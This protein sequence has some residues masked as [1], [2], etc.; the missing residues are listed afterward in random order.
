MAISL[1]THQ[2]QLERY[3]FK[4]KPTREDFERMVKNRLAIPAMVTLDKITVLRIYGRRSRLV[5]WASDEGIETNRTAFDQTWANIGLRLVSDTREH[6]LIEVP[7]G[8]VPPLIIVS[9]TRAA[10]ETWARL[11]RIESDWEHAETAEALEFF[12]DH[13]P[14]FQPEV[15]VLGAQDQHDPG[16]IQVLNT[17]K[18]RARPTRREARQ[19]GAANGPTIPSPFVL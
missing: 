1:S 10:A 6:W 15:V 13:T 16:L 5:Q 9:P 17:K 3:V 8:V 14:L 7:R 2:D 4:T 19:S 12:L 18:W 11:E